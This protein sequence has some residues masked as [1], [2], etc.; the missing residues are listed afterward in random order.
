MA[1][2]PIEKSYPAGITGLMD[3][4]YQSLQGF[5]P[6]TLDLYYAAADQR[7]RPAVI[8]IHGG[9]WQ[10]GDARSL[11]MQAWGS[12]DQ[13]LARLAARGYV[14]VGV[15]YRLSGEVKFPAQI[16]DVKAAVRWLRANA[17]KYHIDP[18]RIAAWGE[19]AGGQ[20]ASLLGTSCGVSELEGNTGNTGQSSCV[21]AVIDWYGPIDFLQQ[22]A[23]QG[24]AGTVPSS[25]E[26]ALLGC[27]LAR[28][29]PELVRLSNATSF[30][31]A[32]DPPF[33]VMHGDADTAV[34]MSQ[35]RKFVDALQAKGVRA[36]LEIIPGAN[37][38]WM[39]ASAAQADGILKT[40][41][42]FLDRSFGVTPPR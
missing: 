33:L 17:Q 27:A 11:A 3:V 41:F 24:A 4:T 13:L 35:S 21:Q 37:H 9:G 22:P 32:G 40:V 14:T 16:Q 15:S 28:C 10:G 5:R 31:D 19:S 1:T 26:A 20:L 23:N 12:M 34:P 39:G 30:L 2:A 7:P 25:P 6:L 36:Q 42:D 38:V 29:A 8:W 18:Q